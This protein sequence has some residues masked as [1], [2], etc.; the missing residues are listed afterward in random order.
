MPV[1]KWHSRIFIANASGRNKPYLR[2]TKTFVTSTSSRNPSIYPSTTTNTWTW[3]HMRWPSC[4]TIQEGFQ[5]TILSLPLRTR[6]WRNLAK[7][8]D[9]WKD[10]EMKRKRWKY[11]IEEEIWMLKNYNFWYQW[12]TGRSMLGR[13]RELLEKGRM[14]ERKRKGWVVASRSGRKRSFCERSSFGVRVTWS[15]VNL[16][17][18]LYKRHKYQCWVREVLSSFRTF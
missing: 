16:V 3:N 11:N 6:K 13:W 9:G 14:R 15:D 2:S 4:K 17:L 5:E 12:L 7:D 1:L 18:E 8:R 10:K